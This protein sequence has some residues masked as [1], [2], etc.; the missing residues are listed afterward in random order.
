MQFPQLYTNA[1]NQNPEKEFLSGFFYS[2]VKKKQ[3]SEEN[4][5]NVNNVKIM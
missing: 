2:I 5:Q 4:L 3:K 1:I